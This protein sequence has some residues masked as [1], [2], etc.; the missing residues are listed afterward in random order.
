MKTLDKHLPKVFYVFVCLLLV[1]LY[2][3]KED[4]DTTAPEITIISPENGVTYDTDTVWFRY[5][6]EEEHPLEAF[7]KVNTDEQRAVPFAG[8]QKIPVEDGNYTIVLKARDSYNNSSLKDLMF[9]INQVMSDKIAPEI[10]IHSPEN[11]QTYSTDTIPF[12]YEIIEKNFREDGHSWYEID[13]V[14]TNASKSKIEEL[15]LEE[16]N[17][18]I[19]VHAEDKAQN[20]TEDSVIFSV[21]LPVDTIPPR[22]NIT[23]PVEGEYYQIH[24][25]PL[26][27]SIDEERLKEATYQVYSFEKRYSSGD[28]TSTN[29]AGGSISKLTQEHLNLKSGNYELIVEAKDKKS[30][31]SSDTINFKVRDLSNVKFIINLFAQPND[32]TLNWYGSGDVDGDN[33]SATPGDIS[34]LE[35][36]LNKTYTPDINSQD[37]VERRTLD[38]A[39]VNGDGEVNSADLGLLK[40]KYAGNLPYFP[41]EW[42]KLQTRE[43]RESWIKKMKIIEGREDWITNGSCL[44]YA[45]Q[46]MINFQG[47]VQYGFNGLVSG[48]NEGVLLDIRDNGRFNLPVYQIGIYPQYQTAHAMNGIIVGDSLGQS[49]TNISLNLNHL[50]LKT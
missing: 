26:E 43:E 25:I 41:G 1:L 20:S 29:V 45:R 21:K 32:S 8:L 48:V 31:I 14:R 36:I 50:C 16:G 19:I 30:N 12:S 7:L 2:S 42:N 5:Q 44:D 47:F 34:R 37:V 23:S 6:I 22:I 46:F 24:T 40:Q 9:T 10:R 18:K 27:I 49:S 4:P 3:C 11:N 13:S 28:W 15:V 17:H 39:D 38:R 35:N 33:V